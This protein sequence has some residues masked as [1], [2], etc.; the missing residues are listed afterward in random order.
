MPSRKTIFIRPR[1]IKLRMKLKS[2][3]Q[4][5]K[6]KT[7]IY[8]WLLAIKLTEHWKPLASTGQNNLRPLLLAI[9]PFVIML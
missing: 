6:M 2:F 3:S 8:R 4:L 9:L 1:M 5:V 7:N